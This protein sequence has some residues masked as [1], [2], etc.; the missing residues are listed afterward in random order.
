M[1][2]LCPK[3][4]KKY[5]VADALA[6]KRARCKN[7]SCGQVFTVGAGT[8]SAPA[9]AATP[10]A[11]PAPAAGGSPTMSSLLDELPPMP[12][13][14]LPQ[15]G[16][17]F[18]VAPTY[19]PSRPKG[20]RKNTWRSPLLL[21]LGG[22]IVALLIVGCLLVMLVSHLSLGGSA[23]KWSPYDYLPENAQFVASADLD[24]LRDSDLHADIRKFIGEQSPQ[25]PGD[26]NFDDISEAFVAGC[27]F[28]PN[29]DPLV[30]LRMK[31]DL[32]VLPTGRRQQ[33]TKSYQ[34]VEYVLRE[35]SMGRKEGFLAKTGE[36]TF[37]I[38]PTEDMLKQVIDRLGRKERAK[39]AAS[40]QTAI[41]AVA[42]SRDYVAGI[43]L[44]IPG[45]PFTIDRFCG[46]VSVASS[47]RIEVTLVFASPDEATA[48]KQFIDGM[49]G[50]MAIM[51]P[52]KKKVLDP[53]L[54]ALNIRQNGKEL[55]FDATWQNQD[56]VA[57]VKMA[58]ESPPAFP[59]KPGPM[60]FGAFPPG[61]P[62]GPPPAPR[63]PGQ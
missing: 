59:G 49:K 19:R 42:G 17:P 32:Y 29:D 16:V 48:C 25:V 54:S 47:L 10:P 12:M 51:P 36:R 33:Q 44:K 4:Q 13:D 53:I 34:N 55:S 40:L 39:P 9:P 27:G 61:V 23:A 45:M 37:C 52:D 46:R 50:M 63:M 3:C 5:L 30:V 6:G 14:N 22:G 7:Q 18:V 56:I 24:E 1:E 60:P 41:D 21:K 43:N 20:S 26:L 38:A 62:G 2:I 15:E 28:G 57:L 35:N 11:K 58:K 8:T 31:N